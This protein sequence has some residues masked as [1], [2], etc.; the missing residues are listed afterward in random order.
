M[1]SAPRACREPGCGKIAERDGG[2][3][4]AA[5]KDVNSSLEARA[6]FDRDRADDE[7]RKLYATAR[8]LTFRMWLIGQNPICQ[9]INHWVRCT[10]PSRL[11]HHIHSPRLR[12]DL[13]TS[14]ENCI[15]LCFD[16]HTPEAGTPS[17]VAGVDFEPTTFRLPNFG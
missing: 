7:T 2:G 4:C 9:K 13:F 15:C 3:Y 5:H 11:V 8:W 6:A 16:C 12:P 14:A 17:W 10:R 1:L